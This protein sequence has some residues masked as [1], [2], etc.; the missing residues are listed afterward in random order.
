M[1]PEEAEALRYM[2]SHPRGVAFGELDEGQRA[3]VHGAAGVLRRPR[4]PDDARP[5]DGPHRRR[6]DGRPALRLGGGDGVLQGHYYRLQGPVTLIEFNNTEDDANHA[7][8]VWRDPA[9]DFGRD[10][11]MEHLVGEHRDGDTHG[12]G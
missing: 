8:S 11:L 10:L 9:N 2:K 7:H 12:H 1:R 3:Q 4:A 6:R 5:G